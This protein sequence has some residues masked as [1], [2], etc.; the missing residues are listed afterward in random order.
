[1]HCN[2]CILGVAG[3]RGRRILE[4]PIISLRPHTSLCP[5]Q[6]NGLELSN[7]LMVVFGRHKEHAP[8]HLGMFIR[9]SATVLSSI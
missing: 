2:C 7:I 5:T 6:R 8:Q 1:M 4:V 9:S 3:G